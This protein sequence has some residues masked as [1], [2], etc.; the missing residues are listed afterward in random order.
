MMHSSATG[1][2]RHATQCQRRFAMNHGKDRIAPANTAHTAVCATLISVST[3][4]AY[5]TSTALSVPSLTGKRGTP[6]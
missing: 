3:L 4:A 5:S 6:K 1:T 2:I